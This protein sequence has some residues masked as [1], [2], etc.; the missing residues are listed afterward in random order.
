MQKL[1]KQFRG[2]HGMDAKKQVR[3]VKIASYIK[4]IKDTEEILLKSKKAKLLMN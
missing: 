3:A 4:W 2:I 1:K